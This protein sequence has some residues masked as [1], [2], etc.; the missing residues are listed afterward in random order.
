MSTPATAGS[1]LRIS[2]PSGKRSRISFRCGGTRSAGCAILTGLL[3]AACGGP[4]LPS[5]SGGPSTSPPPLPAVA[6]TNSTA[7]STSI[8]PLDGDPAGLSGSVE[9]DSPILPFDLNDL[10][11]DDPALRRAALSR[12][13]LAEYERVTPPMVLDL[14]GLMSAEIDDPL[15]LEIASASAPRDAIEFLANLARS[16]DAAAAQPGALALVGRVAVEGPASAVA[17][18]GMPTNTPRPDEVTAQMPI[19]PDGWFATAL[20]DPRRPLRL[21]LHGYRAVDYVPGMQGSESTARFHNEREIIRLSPLPASET[22]GIRGRVVA[23]GPIPASG[24]QVQAWIRFEPVN[25]PD[26]KFRAR[27]RWPQAVPIPLQA[28]GSFELGGFSAARYHIS[29]EAEGFE[30]AAVDA[31][32]PLGGSLDLGNLRLVASD[33]GLYLDEAAAPAPELHWLSDPESAFAQARAEGR[34]LLALTSAAWCPPCQL[35]ESSTL[36]D[37]WVRWMLGDL[38]LLRV[39]EDPDFNTTHRA[40]SY[41][42]LIF[43]DPEGVER[44]RFSGYQPTLPF[45]REC[46]TAFEALDLPLPAPIQALVDR[47]VL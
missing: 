9:E 24:I 25:T 1:A 46:L 20:A 5:D 32:L 21:Q 45:L 40:P 19:H 17:A 10:A 3:L 13:P 42:S 36:R 22:A 6:S 27:S 28:D 37:P 33:L 4:T 41:P 16:L 29:A 38:L 18:G 15:P 26:G 43:F 39:D 31:D 35:L 30:E 47:G 14:A 2:R 34:P 23:D 44:H 8:R 7:E 12:L 11:S